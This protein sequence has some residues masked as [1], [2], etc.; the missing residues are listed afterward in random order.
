[1]L[2]TIGRTFKGEQ[3]DPSA[4]TSMRL[5]PKIT[6]TVNFALD[7]RGEERIMNASSPPS[8]V[9]ATSQPA[10]NRGFTFAPDS[11]EEE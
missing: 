3:L 1:M 9:K 4:F 11:R 10:F 2:S 7:S 6:N 5:K 8:L